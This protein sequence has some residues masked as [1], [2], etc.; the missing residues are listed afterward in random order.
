MWYGKESIDEVYIMTLGLCVRSGLPIRPRHQ[1]E[2]QVPFSDPY[3]RSS[4]P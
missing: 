4:R 3:Q 1:A 2:P